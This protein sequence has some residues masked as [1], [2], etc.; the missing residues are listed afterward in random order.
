MITT[1]TIQG[2]LLILPTDVM[3]TCPIFTGNMLQFQGVEFLLELPHVDEVCHELGI[4]AAAI[5]SDLLDD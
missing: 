1:T 3:P 4:V 5:P 2:E